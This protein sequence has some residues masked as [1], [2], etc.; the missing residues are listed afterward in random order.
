MLKKIFLLCIVFA[1]VSFSIPQIHALRLRAATREG[2]IANDVRCARLTDELSALGGVW[3]AAVLSKGGY[4][5]VGIR[6]DRAVKEIVYNKAVELAKVYFPACTRKVGVEDELALD[7]T[8]L[9]HFMQTDIEDRV[10]TNRFWF[11][12]KEFDKI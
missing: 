7:V 12:A 6:C 9:A 5:L 3:E 11:I 8:Q 4:V 10:I 1:A 2:L